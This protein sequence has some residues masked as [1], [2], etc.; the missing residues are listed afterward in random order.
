[1]SYL[2]LYLTLLIFGICTVIYCQEIDSPGYRTITLAD[3]TIFRDKGT[4]YL[5]GTGS[6]GAANVGSGFVVYTS[7]DLKIWDG[8]AGA[9]GGLAL[10]SGDAYGTR[11]FWAPQVIRYNNKFYMAYT[12]N[13]QIGIAVADNPGGPFVNPSMKAIDESVKQIDP[14]IFI[15]GDGKKYLYHVRLINGN[16]IFVA[17]LNDDLMSIKPETLKECI[18]A[19]VKW[20]NTAGAQ[21]PVA[22]GPTVIKHRNL[23]YLI[24]S[25]N[26]F[27]NP[28]YAVGYATS[29]SPL[30]PW[31]KSADSPF[32]SRS[33]IG[34]N[35]TGHGDVL[36]MGNGDLLYVFHTH[37][38]KEAVN[39]RKTAIA[40]IR[41][42]KEKHEK[43]DKLVLDS[44]TF[45]YLNCKLH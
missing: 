32:I 33:I 7:A 3:P 25:A 13:E 36:D 38:S 37:F 10:R 42:V 19:E 4:Y 29:K 1:M 5:Y 28:D 34:E 31:T 9:A 41:F 30:G 22:E 27:R 44:T 18:S 20:E 2:R 6:G 12:A 26:D 8:P 14:F 21:W 45:R 39:P 35:G 15:D 23:Y 24:Y 16:R 17:E 11:G 40:E 43:T